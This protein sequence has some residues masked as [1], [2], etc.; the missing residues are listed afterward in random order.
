MPY[1]SRV[2]ESESKYRS[3]IKNGGDQF[4]G[5]SEDDSKNTKPISH[6][7]IELEEVKN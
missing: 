2:P 1:D 6:G 4:E 3:D 7:D 5:G